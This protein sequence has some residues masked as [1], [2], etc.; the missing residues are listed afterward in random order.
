[1]ASN[2]W[3]D[4][5]FVVQG[6]TPNSG[7]LTGRSIDTGLVATGS[8]SAGALALVSSVNVF[9]TVASS[10]GARLPVGF[11]GASVRIRNGGTNTLLPYPP[12]GGTL[13]GGSI[14]AAGGTIAAV[15]SGVPGS[16]SFLCTST[17]GLTWV[18]EG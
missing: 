9:A 7:T 8:N 17:D 4:Q 10:T 12:T 2:L 16:A 18:K 1:M 13:N 3:S 14:D 11:E 5:G 6:M 15:S